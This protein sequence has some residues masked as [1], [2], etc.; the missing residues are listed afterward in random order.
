VTSVDDIGFHLLD[1]RLELAP[2]N[3]RTEIV[4]PPS[5]LDR[6]VGIYELTPSRTVTI[7]RSKG[8]LLAEA[9]GLGCALIYPSSET[10]FFVKVVPIQLT[11]ELDRAGTAIGLTLHHGNNHEH[12][13]RAVAGP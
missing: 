13:A 2:A 1:T 11:F 12:G 10:E 3:E 9:S 4:L 5:T 6:Y 8:G 7:T